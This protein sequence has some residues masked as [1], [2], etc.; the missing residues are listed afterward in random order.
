LKRILIMN[1]LIDWNKFGADVEVKILENTKSG[2]IAYITEIDKLTTWKIYHAHW[3]DYLSSSDYFKNWRE[4]INSFQTIE[5]VN[6][7]ADRLRAF[8]DFVKE[9]T[10]K[11]IRWIEGAKQWDPINTPKL[12][13]QE[14]KRLE[15]VSEEEFNKTD[16]WKKKPV[17]FKK[18]SI[19]EMKN[20]P[21]FSKQLFDK[22]EKPNKEDNNNINYQTWTKNQLISEINR[23]KTENEQ[24][25]NN[26]T[27]TTSERQERLQQNQQKLEQIA[28][29][30]GVDSK[31]NNSNNNFPTSL[32]VGGGVLATAGLIGL[33][34]V[35][36]NKKKK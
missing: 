27:L 26:Q 7:Y 9:H 20:D 16:E 22:E 24:L 36:K 23:L 6:F 29:Y 13:G 33:L 25:K 2:S 8:I 35:T 31:S 17:V 10:R 30:V 12:I 18:L 21:W 14:L 28:S 4:K 34:I 5:E 19:E 11:D 15:N 32:V 1:T 3:E